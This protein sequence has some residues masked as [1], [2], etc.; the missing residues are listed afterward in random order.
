MPT[1]NV[2]LTK[3]MV[4]YVSDEVEAGEY[5]SASEVVRDA[6]RRHKLERQVERDKLAILRRELQLGIDQMERGEFSSK[7]IADIANEVIAE[8]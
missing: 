3:E 7:S 1:M 6:L 4:D 8:G 5:G 2:S